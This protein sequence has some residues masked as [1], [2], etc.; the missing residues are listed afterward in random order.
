MGQLEFETFMYYST[1][2]ENGDIYAFFRLP[3]SDS[4]SNPNCE[5]SSREGYNGCQWNRTASG[6]EWSKSPSWYIHIAWER[7]R[8]HYKDQMESIVSC[9]N[10]HKRLDQGQVR[11]PIVSFCASPI[12]PVLFPCSVNKPSA[13]PKPR[14]L[15]STATFS[16]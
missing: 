3:D 13:A 6:A 14:P 12:P 7:D 10:V 16:E 4:D 11:R 15:T 9:R 2:Q 5:S 8:E 1:L